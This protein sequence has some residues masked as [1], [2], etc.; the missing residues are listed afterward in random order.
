MMMMPAYQILVT[1]I[2]TR[3][4]SHFSG[5]SKGHKEQAMRGEGLS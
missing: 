4:L 2:I 5:I 1:V 3:Y